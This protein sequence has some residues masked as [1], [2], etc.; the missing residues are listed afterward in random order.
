MPGLVYI[1][2]MLTSLASAVLLAR[3]A[4]GPGRRLLLCSAVSFVGM[5]LNNVALLAD[6]LVG[7]TVDWS[8]WPHLIALAS[9]AILVYGLIWES[10]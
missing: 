1:L 9:A 4:T 3:A 2:C 8:V 6:A 7:P 10:T 5:A